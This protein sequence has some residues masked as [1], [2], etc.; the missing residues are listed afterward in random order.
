MQVVVPNQEILENLWTL[1]KTLSQGFDPWNH[2]K[3]AVFL[4]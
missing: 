3:A 4:G 2:G 1:E